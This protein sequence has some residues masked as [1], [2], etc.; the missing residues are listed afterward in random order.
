MPKKKQL[1]KW[2]FLDQNHGLT[3]F[4]KFFQLFF[5]RQYRPGK[6]LSWYSRAKERLSRLQ[7]GNIF[8]DFLR[9][10]NAFLGYKNKML[11][12]SKN[13]HFYKG[14]NSWLWSKIGRFSIFSFRQYSPGKWHFSKGFSPWFCSKNGHFTSFF[15]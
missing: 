9:Q 4:Q 8:Y 14:V 15:F 11:K 2:P 3:P 12:K 7:K 6:C 5:F 1:E 13:S 10:K